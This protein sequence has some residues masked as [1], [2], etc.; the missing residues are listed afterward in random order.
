M[1]YSVD[2]KGSSP[3]PFCFLSFPQPRG[4]HGS[5]PS[6]LGNGAW[7]EKHPCPPPPTFTR[8]L[9]QDKPTEQTVSWSFLSEMCSEGPQRDNLLFQKQLSAKNKALLSGLTWTYPGL[10][11]NHLDFMHKTN[12][13]LQ[14]HCGHWL[15]YLH[16][17]K[18]TVLNRTRV[19]D[20]STCGP[21]GQTSL[22]IPSH[23]LLLRHRTFLLAS[24]WC[25]VG[26]NN[27][28]KSG[29]NVL[30]YFFKIHHT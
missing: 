6:P 11:D 25:K 22:L 8:L 23:P 2:S 12:L 19:P 18:S 10:G 13:W 26:I 17:L 27:R 28:E 3:A 21:L 15:V 9:P 1:R 7:G 20:G 30:G 4:I 29:G 14:P 16:H 5:S 24:D